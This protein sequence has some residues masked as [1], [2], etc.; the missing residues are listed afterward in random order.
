MQTDLNQR[1]RQRYA[2]QLRTLSEAAGKAAVALEAE[3][4]V[5]FVIQYLILGILGGTL[6]TELKPIVEAAASAAKAT[7][8]LEKGEQ[9]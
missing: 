5:R 9:P 3:D 6:I 7:E 1:E 8:E 2:K 4:D